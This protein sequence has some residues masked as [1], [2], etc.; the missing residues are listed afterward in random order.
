MAV[1]RGW[2]ESGGGGGKEA[3]CDEYPGGGP[4]LDLFISTSNDEQ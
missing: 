3:F 1:V 4:D 2:Q